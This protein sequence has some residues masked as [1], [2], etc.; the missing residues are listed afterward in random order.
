[1]MTTMA[2]IQLNLHKDVD[3]ASVPARIPPWC[4]LLLPAAAAAATA[5]A[6]AGKRTLLLL[7]F[8]CCCCWLGRGNPEVGSGSSSSRGARK[9]T[10]KIKNPP[11]LPLDLV[12]PF[13]ACSVIRPVNRHARVSQSAAAAAV[14]KYKIAA[15]SV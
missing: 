3:A 2:S 11:L 8:C 12:I 10:T 1:M 6:A 15:Y 5:S 13:A 4:L 9:T 7:L 14:G